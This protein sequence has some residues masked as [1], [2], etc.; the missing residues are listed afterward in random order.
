MR[1]TRV[2]GPLGGNG[3]VDHERPYSNGTTRACQ[4]PQSLVNL[5]KAERAQHPQHGADT[6]GKQVRIL[7]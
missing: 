5:G 2:R 1:P 7:S 4:A 6:R 3:V